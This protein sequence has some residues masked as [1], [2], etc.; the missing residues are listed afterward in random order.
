MPPRKKQRIDGDQVVLASRRTTRAS[1]KTARGGAFAED[2]PVVVKEKAKCKMAEPNAPNDAVRTGHLQTLPNLALEVQLE[3]SPRSFDAILVDLR[4]TQQIYNYLDLE[5]IFNLSLT[6]KKFRA[7][8]MDKALEKR[9]WVPARANTPG[10][11][12]RPPW[13]GECAFAYLLYSPHCHV[14]CVFICTR[15]RY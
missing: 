6:C 2:P 7:F 11:P 10:L 15:E 13:I 1:A 9:V 4:P 14:G 3:A 8:F 12:D 5:D